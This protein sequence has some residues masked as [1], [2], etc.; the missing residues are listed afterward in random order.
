M[1]QVV[2]KKFG[3]EMVSYED[4]REDYVAD[5]ELTVTITLAEYRRL[6]KT[7]AMRDADIAE[8]NTEIRNLKSKIEQLLNTLGEQSD[9]ADF[10]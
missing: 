8:R 9:K 10:V 3:K 6:I 7:A 2:S 4:H 5:R 1:E